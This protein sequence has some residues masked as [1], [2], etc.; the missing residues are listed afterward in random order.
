MGGEEVGGFKHE[1]VCRGG[2]GFLNIL[3]QLSVLCCD[4][5]NLFIWIFFITQKNKHG[6]IV[7][8]YIMRFC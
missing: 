6:L 2:S 7:S 1:C 4:A 5:F 8:S 3:C